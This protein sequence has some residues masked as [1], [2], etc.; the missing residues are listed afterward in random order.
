MTESY[1]HFLWSLKRLPFHLFKTTEG[2]PI[3]ILSTGKYNSFES[4]P[5]FSNAHIL[6]DTLRWAGHIEI[7]VKSSDWYFHHHHLDPAYNNVILHVVYEHDKEVWLNGSFLPTIE[8]KSFIDRHHY[9]Y[10]QRFLSFKKD[11]YCADFISSIDLFFFKAMMHRVLID[12]LNRKGQHILSLYKQQGKVA[13]LYSLIAQSFGKKTNSLPFELLTRRVPFSYLQDQNSQTQYDLLLHGSGIYHK[14]HI[15]YL[16]SEKYSYILPLSPSLWRNKGIR[17]ASFPKKRLIQFAQFISLCN[18]PKLASYCTVNEAQENLL[19]IFS[20]LT[21]QNNEAFSKQLINHLYINAFIPYY[22]A[23]SIELEDDIIKENLISFLEKIPRESNHI[24][25]KWKK[26]KILP[27]NAYESQGLIEL[28]N[29]HC[30]HKK[31]L[32]CQVGVKI[33]KR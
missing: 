14:E 13:T 12:R 27:Q 25:E 3:T 8:L 1:L 17:P 18:L 32:N 24:I 5:D 9:A 19:P 30:L 22:W 6:Y 28:Y 23:K 7:H 29:E 33:M 11:I 2:K 31:C 4:G 15:S 20:Q 16:L 10:W 21:K 26:T